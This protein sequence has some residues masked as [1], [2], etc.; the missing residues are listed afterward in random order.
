MLVEETEQLRKTI[1]ELREKNDRLTNQIEGVMSA[2]GNKGVS[3]VETA[4]Y[5]E[6]LDDK[7]SR[8]KTLVR[9]L[10]EE[11]ENFHKERKEMTATVL[12]QCK[13]TF[14]I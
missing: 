6:Q 5:R 4:F 7:E 9:Q 12:T 14:C 11:R 2:R 13:S 3:A 8:L 1:A 10:D